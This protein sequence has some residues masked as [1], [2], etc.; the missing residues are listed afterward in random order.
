METFKRH[1][2]PLQSGDRMVVKVRKPTIQQSIAGER[3]F[4]RNCLETNGDWMFL[5]YADVE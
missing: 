2:M 1:G 5:H 4:T 3:D